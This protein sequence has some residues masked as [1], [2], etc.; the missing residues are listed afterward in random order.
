MGSLLIPNLL[1]TETGKWL[2]W[3]CATTLLVARYM[4]APHIIGQRTCLSWGISGDRCGNQLCLFCLFCLLCVNWC[5]R[6][7]VAVAVT[8]PAVG[9]Y[10][11]GDDVASTTT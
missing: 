7:R 6:T 11:V 10:L 3:L 5:W 2:K 4:H 8:L 1:E 9:I